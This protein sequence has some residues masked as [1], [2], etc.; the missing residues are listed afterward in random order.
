MTLEHFSIIDTTLRE[1]EQFYKA[2]FSF[3]DKARIAGLLSDFGVEF[4]EVTSPCASPKS[5]KHCK[6]LTAMGLRSKFLAHVRCNRDDVLA[7]L[8]T[9]VSGI[10]FFFHS[11]FFHN[12]FGQDKSPQKNLDII[13]DVLEF[14]RQQAPGIDIRF[15]IEDAFRTRL[16]DLIVIY[17]AVIESG[18]VHRLGVADTVGVALPGEVSRIIRLLKTL[19]IAQIEFHGH[20][21]TECA[22]A[23]SL[24]ALEAGATHID[25][26]VL[27]IGERN[28]I[29]SLAG[30]VARIYSRHPDLIKNKYQLGQLKLIHETLAQCLGITI[31]FNHP[32]VGEAA[33]VH[34]A[35][36]HTNSV[37]NDPKSYEIIDPGDFNA[38][39]TILIGH[40]LTGWNAIRDRVKQLGLDLDDHAIK[41]LTWKI[42]KI[43]DT[44]PMTMPQVDRLL[45]EAAQQKNINF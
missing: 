22:V 6:A 35:G 5:K 2:N 26:S 40:K 44:T 34:K 13:M 30:L 14:T 28:G 29:T 39:R 42:K 24:A 4:I 17:G 41:Q 38:L 37:I 45:K 36:I 3:K 43:A 15:S 7:A 8:E 25:T 27:G 20:N 31:P 16:E 23:N 18:L 32:I 10:N 12:R 33:F 21:D 1:G 9:G 19:G 11:R